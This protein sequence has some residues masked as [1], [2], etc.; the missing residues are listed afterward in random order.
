MPDARQTALQILNTLDQKK[1]TLD[2]ALENLLE[3][4]EEISKKDRSLTHSLV[5]GVTRW[6]NKL[7]WI[8]GHYSKTPLRK[9]D[10]AVLNI[11]RIGIFQILYMDRIP[12]S[13]AV[14]TSVELGKLSNPPWVTKFINGLLRNVARHRSDIPFPSMEADFAKYLSISCSFPLWLIE[15]WLARYTREETAAMCEAA[16]K[17]PPITIRTNTLKITREKLE[18]A[19]VTE[20]KTIEPTPYSPFG[21]RLTAPKTPISQL[22]AFQNGWFQVQDEAA[23]IVSMLMAPKPG[24]KVLDACAGLGGKT[25]HLAQMMNNQGQLIA[26]DNNTQK[27]QKLKNEMNR[28]G[29]HIVETC[30]F[31]LLHHPK[32]HLSGQFDHV[33]LDAPCSGLGVIRRN[34][35]IK[36]EESKKDLDSYQKRQIL[37]LSNLVDLLKPGGRLTFAVCS[38]ETEETD[39]VVESFLNHHL[40]FQLED[41]HKE[42]PCAMTPIIY[43]DRRLTTY[44]HRDSMDGF[45]SV[46]FRK[47][48]KQ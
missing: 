27:L 43:H 4:K 14:N 15:K 21:L 36:W 30:P 39:Q 26:L 23:Q 29:V 32:N 11:L 16:N 2:H 45:F 24:Q 17:I 42:L 3:K 38:T 46:C 48:G 20:V 5:F 44:P 7:D 13:A 41:R 10:P 35:D 33:L 19:L 40:D 8:I 12:D 25:A 34:P 18:K 22:E 1:G 37:F 6:R 31:D 9:M 28:L 47:S